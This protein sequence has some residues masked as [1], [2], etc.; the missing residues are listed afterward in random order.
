[1]P[2]LQQK[3]RVVLGFT[4][5]ELLV[6]ALMGAILLASTAG[7]VV[8]TLSIDREETGRSEILGD[9]SQVV[10]FIARDISEALYIYNDAEQ[11]A[12]P[13]DPPGDGTP[14]LLQR[15]YTPGWIK[16]PDDSIPVVSFWRLSEELPRDCYVGSPNREQIRRGEANLIQ[17]PSATAVP[18]PVP[19]ALTFGAWQDISRRR[20][21]YTLVTYYLRSN[22]NNSGDLIGGTNW[23]GNARI[24]RYELRP[25]TADCTA[26]NPFFIVDPEPFQSSF[27]AWPPAAAGQLPAQPNDAADPVVV[28]SNIYSSRRERALVA[29]DCS[30][31]FGDAYAS[32]GGKPATLPTN[33]SI[34][35]APFQELSENE[36]DASFYV[37]V[38]RNIDARLPQDVIIN[39]TTTSLNRANTGLFNRY[40]EDASVL[41]DD[42]LET[43]LHP[44]ET[45]ILS[46][47]AISRTS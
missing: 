4:I 8:R 40:I 34:L 7:I 1:M 30:V 44:A 22:F 43:F 16:R 10:D 9:L 13:A 2:K 45:R 18:P 47:G 38:R 11:P 28:T 12:D 20:S 29:P 26:R 19:P 32:A 6:A 17:G 41:N 42:E 15:L 37:C 23:E 21:V 31:D 27:L 25:L 39:I 24:S 14:D 33:E 35:N 3:N 36:S 5:I 46:R